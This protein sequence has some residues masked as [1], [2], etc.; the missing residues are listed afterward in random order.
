MGWDGT[1]GQDETSRDGMDDTWTDTWVYLKDNLERNLGLEFGLVVNHFDVIP[2]AAN[3][4]N[5]DL[6]S[7]GLI[8]PSFL[9]LSF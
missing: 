3:I 5:L 9:S 7:L 6:K 1:E 2:S 8:V 4:Y